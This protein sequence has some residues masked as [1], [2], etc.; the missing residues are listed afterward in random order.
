MARYG[1]LLVLILAIGCEH[2]LPTQMSGDTTF[3]EETTTADE[4]FYQSPLPED[5]RRRDE[6]ISAYL[7]HAADPS[8]ADTEWASTTMT[9]MTFYAAPDQQWNLILELIDRA[10]D[11]ELVLQDIAAGPLE[12]LLG[13]F[14][15][16]VIADVEARASAEPKFARVVSGVWQHGMSDAT[17]QRVRDIQKTVDRPLPEMRPFDR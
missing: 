13:R 1:L 16:D 7:T 5:H 12:G 3:N 4:I 10:P 2:H 17:W 11:N 15:D 6:V 8:D 14:G 9:G